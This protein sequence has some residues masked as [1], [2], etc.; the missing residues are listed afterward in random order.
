MVWHDIFFY[1]FLADNV[2]KAVYFIENF[3]IIRLLVMKYP[4]AI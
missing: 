4:N 1:K 2:Q 3:C